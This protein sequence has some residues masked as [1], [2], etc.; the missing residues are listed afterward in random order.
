[1]A[2]L[3]LLL[4]TLPE[5]LT[6]NTLLALDELAKGDRANSSK[7]TNKSSGPDIT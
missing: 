3:A 7:P 2:L 6:L 5:L 4:L 1:L